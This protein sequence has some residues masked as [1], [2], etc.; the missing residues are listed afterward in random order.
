MEYNLHNRNEFKPIESREQLPE[1]L[2][3][4]K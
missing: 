4:D 3:D 2:G 1:F